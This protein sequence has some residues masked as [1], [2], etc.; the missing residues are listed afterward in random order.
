MKELKIG[1]HK[2]KVFD[3]IEDL[4]I[5]RHHKF[6]KLML[7]DA[8]IGSDIT[9]FDAHMERVIRYIR[10]NKAD[11]AEKELLNLRQNI[12]MV[13]SEISPK[14]M[15]FAALIQNLDGE[16]CNDL[17][18]E[19]LKAVLAKISDVTVA[20]IDQV[21]DESKK[22]LDLELQTY[23][24]QLFD[25]AEVKE[26]YDKLKR[27][28]IL[29]LDQLEKGEDFTEAEEEELER[30]TDE[31]VLFSDPHSFSGPES[32]EIQ[33]DKQFENACLAISQHT[34]SDAKRFTTLEYYNALFYLREQAKDLKK[35]R[36]KK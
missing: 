14:H 9:D 2:L 11:L 13:Q 21:L 29:L 23:F 7:I 4:P 33:Q 8:H 18:D 22:K 16:D 19:A 17:S 31:L 6:S 15:A 36:P 5:V 34:H 28:T 26:Y 10:S 25:G 20:E 30:I 3:S 1:K 24:P 35:K 12:F 27:R 32:T